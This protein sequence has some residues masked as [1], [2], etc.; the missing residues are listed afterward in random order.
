[1]ADP[2]STASGLLALIV[3]AGQSS[4]LLYQAVDSFKSNKKIVRELREEVGALDG[5]LQSLQ[6]TASNTNADLAILNVPLRRCGEACVA[7]TAVIDKCTAHS[8]GP[9]TSFRDWAKLT[10]LG[11]DITGFKDTLAGYKSTIIIALADLNL[12]V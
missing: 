7:F 5:V 3:F 1:M 9:R 6:A 8:G 12:Y 4:K 2:I 10:Y 11:N